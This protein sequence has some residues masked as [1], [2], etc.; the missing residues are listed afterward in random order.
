[1]TQQE[2]HAWLLGQDNGIIDPT[3][4][5]TSEQAAALNPRDESNM[6]SAFASAGNFLR[7]NGAPLATG[8]GGLAAA[9]I[10]IRNR[11]RFSEMSDTLS[12]RSIARKADTTSILETLEHTAYA[13]SGASKPNPSRNTTGMSADDLTKR[14]VVNFGD[15]TDED[16]EKLSASPQDDL[17]EKERRRMKR[18][19]KTVAVAKRVASR[20]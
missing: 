6:P 8:L 2:A 18:L 13:P 11:R 5:G 16:L 7:E 3:P 4:Y 9:S 1:L 12:V 20:S 10:Y 17:T 19:V 14:L 15:Y